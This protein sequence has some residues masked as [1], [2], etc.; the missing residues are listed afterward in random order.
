MTLNLFVLM[1]NGEVKTFENAAFKEFTDKGY[2]DIEKAD[3][4]QERI[5]IKEISSVWSA[6]YR[7]L[8]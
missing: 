5:P 7:G 1:N 2:I 8:V 3:G 6:N 4:S